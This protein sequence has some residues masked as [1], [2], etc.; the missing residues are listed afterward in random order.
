VGLEVDHAQ[1]RQTTRAEE[2][3]L[4]VRCAGGIGRISWEANAMLGSKRGADKLEEGICELSGVTI[5]VGRARVQAR[6]NLTAWYDWNWGC[7][8][9]QA[10]AGAGS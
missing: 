3:G 6:D 8:T 10:E 4:E 1:A 7:I 5:T 9:S 2:V